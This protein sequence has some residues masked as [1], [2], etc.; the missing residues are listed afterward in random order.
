M[1]NKNYF[2]LL[3]LCITL[4]LSLFA[5]NTTATKDKETATKETISIKKDVPVLELSGNGRKLV[6]VGRLASTIGRPLTCA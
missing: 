3:A 6:R 2:Q 5:C 1:K 4:S